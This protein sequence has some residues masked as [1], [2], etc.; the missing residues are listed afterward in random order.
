MTKAHDRLTR[1]LGIGKTGK[2]PEIELPQDWKTASLKYALS[3]MH[4]GGTPATSNEDYWNKGDGGIPWVSISDMSGRDSY[5]SDTEKYVTH[6]GVEAA[7]LKV[8]PENTL[9]F[10]MYAS[11]G[12][13]AVLETEAT[14]NQAILGLVPNA[15]NCIQKFL[16]A[17]LQAIQPYLHAF[18]ASNTQDNLS[19]KRVKNLPIILPPVPVQRQIASFL[20]RR[21][22]RLNALVAKQ[23]RLL[24]LLDEKRQ[25]VITRAVTA[26]LNSTVAMKDT[27]VEWLGQIPEHWN[28]SKVGWHYEVQLGKMLDDARISGEHL[29]PYLRNKDVQ[30]W[31]INTQ[32][33]PKMDFTPSEKRKYN[34]KNGDV[35]VCEGGEIGRSAVWTRQNTECYYQK[36]LHRVRAID[37]SQDSFYFCYF[38]EYA[39]KNGVFDLRSNQSTIS[40]LTRE[41]LKKQ[42]IPL[43]PTSEQN[44]IVSKL[45]EATER[46]SEL[47][48]KLSSRIDLLEEKRQALITA[49]VTGQIDVTE[50]RGE[51]QDQTI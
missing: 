12:E 43:P 17:Y 24:D 10:A 37:Q 47:Q 20:D 2:L 33:L 32:N 50:E 28:M 13:T 26:G 27:G 7:R 11:L 14:T 19:A 34:L 30:W 45:D 31:E 36:A 42:K 6:A 46:L 51:I 39:A 40:H 16:H 15:E 22:A 25:T 5:V 35:L 21:T 48:S 29:A 3:S 38:M 9:L 23:K 8:L 18:S 1:V 44:Q 41:K 4:S 49:A